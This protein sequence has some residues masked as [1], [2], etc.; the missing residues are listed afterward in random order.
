VLA[1]TSETI[2]APN[3]PNTDRLIM[4]V[5]SCVLAPMTAQPAAIMATS[6]EPKTMAPMDSAKVRFA[7]RCPPN[8]SAPTF[9]AMATLT[10]AMAHHG[11]RT[12]AG[13]GCRS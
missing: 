1:S 4:A 9:T 11:F 13:T 3:S 7:A 8:R 5:E 12:G 6:S 10:S 2:R